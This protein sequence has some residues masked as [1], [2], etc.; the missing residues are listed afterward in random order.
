MT[1]QTPTDD[2]TTRPET[3]TALAVLM[4]V[5]TVGE[6][7][8]P[9]GAISP[10]LLS[11]AEALGGAVSPAAGEPGRRTLA[12]RGLNGLREPE[13][14]LDL[15]GLPG[16]VGPL[17][18][19]LAGHDLSAV[20]VADTLPDGLVPLLNS[21][22]ARADA[23][24]EGSRPPLTLRGCPQ[25]LVPTPAPE[26]L[27]AEPVP[28]ALARLCAGL[29][30]PGT[31]TAA[32]PPLWA[33]PLTDLLESFGVPVEVA[34]MGVRLALTVTGEV[35]TRP[36]LLPANWPTDPAWMSAVRQ[37]RTG[38]LIVA[39]DGPAAA[40][41]GTLA[42]A[43][44]ERLGLAYL[45]T[46]KLYR[47]TGVAVQRA[48]GDPADPEAAEKAARS[49]D[50]DLLGDPALRTEEAGRAASQVAAIPAVRAA[51]LD[52][53]RG[54]AVTPPDGAWG[55]VL[56]GRDIGTVVCPDAPAK[57]FVTAWPEV[58]AR[59][60]FLELRESGQDAIESR[61]LQDMKERDARDSSRGV[62]P[63]VPASDAIVLDTSDMDR[64]EAL[65]TALTLAGNRLRATP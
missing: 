43:V 46:G 55:A 34:L 13:T 50:T 35:E 41:K 42:R 64:E 12:G 31:T 28:L 32:L 58:R 18:G 3:L 27:E 54:F 44:A 61:I 23:A 38:S 56:D 16:L 5:A 4:A 21:M 20:V 45:D 49:L 24:A 52:F 36:A 17:C 25:P 60:R 22:G 30:A 9:D 7:P 10:R 53:Q 2:S 19:L 63:L 59:R 65:I 48:G 47:A 29:T 57:L 37:D 6:S 51:L 15:S 62:A 40:G 14:P 1:T 8:L 39:V 11:L 33:G 26:E